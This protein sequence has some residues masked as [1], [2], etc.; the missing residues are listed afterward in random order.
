MI[1]FVLDND[2]SGNNSIAQLN[3]LPGTMQ[4]T[5][6]IGI[7]KETFVKE[8]SKFS[9]RKQENVFVKETESRL[10]SRFK[11]GLQPKKEGMQEDDSSKNA[12]L[13]AHSE[14]CSLH[15]SFTDD[16]YCLRAHKIGLLKALFEAHSLGISSIS[17]SLSSW[18]IVASSFGSL[19]NKITLSKSTRALFIALT[20]FQVSIELNSF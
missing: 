11:L 8:R 1:L 20:T 5:F 13:T 12:I 14:R 19:L 2:E 18:V 9:L 16:W 3:T 15:C 10:L 7:R 6:R 4:K 17:E